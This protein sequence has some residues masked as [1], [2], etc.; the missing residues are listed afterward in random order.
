MHELILLGNDLVQYL[1]EC[2]RFL[3]TLKGRLHYLFEVLDAIRQYV[4]PVSLQDWAD[5][6]ALNAVLQST[7]F[8]NL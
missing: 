8:N 4:A 7:S 3:G 2:L 1:Y 6:P 5:S